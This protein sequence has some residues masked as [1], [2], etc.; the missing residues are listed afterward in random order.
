MGAAEETEILGAIESDNAISTTDT[1]AYMEIT[2]LDVQ[3]TGVHSES[4]GVGIKTP[5]VQDTSHK[6]K[7]NED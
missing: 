2:G 1:T 4:T 5:G 6:D 7:N 3:N